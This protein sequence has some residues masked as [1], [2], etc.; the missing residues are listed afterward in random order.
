MLAGDLHQSISAEPR[1]TRADRP[2]PPG[3]ENTFQFAPGDLA[4][5]LP[6][7]GV[8]VVSLHKDD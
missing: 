6:N 8:A 3:T 5:M 4:P 1:A 2:D 7:G